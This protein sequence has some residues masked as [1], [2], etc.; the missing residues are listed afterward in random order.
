LS[1]DKGK[2]YA[3]LRRLLHLVGVNRAVFF[4]AL[5]KIWFAAAG[6]VTLILIAVR[7]TPELQGYYFTFYSL[8]SLQI[9][10]E[11]GMTA[12]IIN[13]S[14]H[15]WSKLKLGENGQVIGDE[16]A[17]SRLRSL[18][19]VVFLWYRVGAVILLVG[20]GLAGFIFFSL[21]ANT[22]VSWVP[23]WLALCLLTAVNLS[24]LP[25]FSLLEGCNQVA[26]VYFYRF[27]QEVIR[28][29]SIWTII[30]L[31]GGLWSLSGSTFAIV[32]WAVV[33]LFAKYRNFFRTLFL[34]AQGAIIDWRKE[35]WPMQW[36]IAVSWLSGY[37][38]Y[39]I[40]TPA[41]F[42]FGGPVVAGQMGM[43]LSMVLALNMI[44]SMWILT[45]A[46]QF[47]IFI[48]KKEYNNLDKLLVHST[49]SAFGIAVLGALIIFSFVSF[50]YANNLAIAERFLPPFLTAF[51]LAAIVLM[52]ISYGQSTY[53]RAHKKEPFVML[54]AMTAILTALSVLIAGS[55][56]G[57]FGIVVLYFSIVALF[58]IPGGTIIWLRCR[59]KWHSHE[60]TFESVMLADAGA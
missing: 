31:G 1:F 7:F 53:L 4:G 41:L 42:H 33:F 51:F 32:A 14:S 47:G 36:R 27:I 13:F 16:R 46:P 21:S 20:M 25:S 12:V 44:S 35:V 30:L 34:P 55:R 54:S 58:V 15:E 56:W 8:V 2:I 9:F 45:K 39:P 19:K 48:A 3:N 49:L 10:V 24:I 60:E 18:V 57:A 5:S 52:Q 43:T 22:G 29:I 26:Q 50:I 28:S 38:I 59:D 11:L 17:L 6:A 37:F 40:F 23:P